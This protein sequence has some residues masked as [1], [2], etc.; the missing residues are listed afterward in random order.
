MAAAVHVIYVC[1][2]DEAIV[3]GELDLVLA[4]D[5]VVHSVDDASAVDLECLRH[6]DAPS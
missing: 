1:V 6:R 4:S 3:P 5:R 2:N